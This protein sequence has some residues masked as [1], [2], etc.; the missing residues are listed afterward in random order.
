MLSFSIAFKEAFSRQ[1]LSLQVWLVWFFLLFPAGPI[2]AQEPL[3]LG[4][5][6]SYLLEGQY[7]EI[8]EDSS[9]D[10][11][12]DDIRSGR[13]PFKRLHERIPNLGITHTV[14]WVK[15]R[16][17]NPTL[18]TKTWIMSF[19][20][21]H[22]G[23][24]EIYSPMPDG[25][26]RVALRGL[27]NI[28]QNRPIKH[29]HHID[30]FTLPPESTTTYYL[31]L[32]SFGPTQIPIRF[33]TDENF[34]ARENRN[35]AFFG[36]YVGALLIM[37]FYNMFLFWG[38]GERV[39]IFYSLFLVSSGLTW[40]SSEGLVFM[41]LWPTNASMAGFDIVIFSLL[42]LLA[43]A[44]FTISFLRTRKYCPKLHPFILAVIAG[45]IVAAG[46]IHFNWELA[47]YILFWLS[48]PALVLFF[49]AGISC[50]RN[51]F[52]PARYFV[53]S[54]IPIIATFTILGLERSGFLPR[55][56]LDQHQGMTASMLEMILISFA[57]A[58]RIN[59]MKREREDAREK[60]LASQTMQ[61]RKLERLVEE[62]TAALDAALA[63]QK[64]HHHELEIKHQ[65]L[66][67]AQEHMIR[68][69]SMAS[70]GTLSAGIAHE[71]R[72]PLNFIN[73]FSKVMVDLADE[74]ART[75]SGKYPELH[76]L[77]ADIP[78][79]ARLTA[80]YGER[81]EMI[82]KAM[83]GWAGE[84]GDWEPVHFNRFV[85]RCLK[86]S[87]YG[88]EIARITVEKNLEEGIEMVEI[89]PHSYSRAISQ[90]AANAVEAVLAREQVEGSEFKPL[91]KIATETTEIGVCFSIWDNGLGIINEHL[92]K[93]FTPFFTTKHHE[94][95]NIGLGLAIAYDAIVDRHKGRIEVESE[96]GSFTHFTIS[97]PHRRKP[98]KDAAR[99]VD[100]GN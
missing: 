60:V 9:H 54:W 29:R 70:M 22:F 23:G 64:Q 74:A 87:L 39:Y 8:M 2:L 85:D 49:I 69:A 31:R 33:S 73:N 75:M 40:L 43:C 46:V 24:I 94:S 47:I 41:Y 95:K 7:I 38:A 65:E 37:F 35:A 86:V 51:G 26:Y 92:N 66:E 81:A 19:E 53:I 42:N 71:L 25:A 58:D 13:Y 57:L 100:S 76:G 88:E 6:S 28:K 96:P 34:A 72:N 62:R 83:V 11:T 30:R 68:Q 90:L 61:T 15:F 1:K 21:P 20:L 63:I 5:E 91:I 98:E 77:L 4:N 50:W 3:V 32:R 55:W 14:H 16:L 93:I 59:R 89:L 52:R 78:E 82:V 67:N 36:A 48:L 44:V 10:L 97:I 12:L 56:S 27:V 99:V 80:K 17:S 45:I 84:G 18:E 79:N